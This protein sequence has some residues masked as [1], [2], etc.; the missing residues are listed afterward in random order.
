MQ[1]LSFNSSTSVKH[2]QNFPWPSPDV[3]SP[4]E[5]SPEIVEVP[6]ASFVHGN[7]EVPIVQ[8]NPEIPQEDPDEEFQNETSD[9]DLSSSDSDS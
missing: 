1:D 4:A 6:N 7:N 9:E 2:D 5:N 3:E 8:E